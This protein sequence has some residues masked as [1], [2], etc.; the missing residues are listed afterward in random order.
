MN[1][2][3]GAWLFL[4]YSICLNFIIIGNCETKYSYKS[5]LLHIKYKPEE[6]ICIKLLKPDYTKKISATVVYKSANSTYQPL[7]S[8]EDKVTFELERS[9]SLPFGCSFFNFKICLFDLKRDLHGGRL[10]LVRN[11]KH[12]RIFNGNI[13]TDIAVFIYDGIYYYNNMI[14]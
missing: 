11:I 5:K 2:L 8:I 14:I 12:L 3:G 9:N 4:L 1:I 7:Y 13:L 6:V 10:H